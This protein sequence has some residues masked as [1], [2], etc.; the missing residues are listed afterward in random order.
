MSVKADVLASKSPRDALLIVATALDQLARRVDQLGAAAG[1]WDSW[2]DDDESSFQ[3]TG[4]AAQP[5]PEPLFTRDPSTGEIIF[6]VCDDSEKRERREAFVGQ[7]NLDVAYGAEDAPEGGWDAL[8]VNAGPMWL[9]LHDR[10]LL[11]QYSYEIRQAMVADVLEDDPQA[12]HE[13]ARDVLKVGLDETGYGHQPAM[14]EGTI[15][16][17]GKK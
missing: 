1:K 16:G 11:I 5:E 12:G 13:M 8:Y 6:R 15:T 3:E 10:D 2:V 4:K 7:L 14:A 17:K 9:Y